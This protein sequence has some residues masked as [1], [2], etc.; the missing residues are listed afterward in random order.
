MA[1]GHGSRS[2][3]YA[4]CIVENEE[5]GEVEELDEEDVILQTAQKLDTPQNGAEDGPARS[6]R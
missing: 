5:R 6:L 1:R 2:G 3:V 4:E